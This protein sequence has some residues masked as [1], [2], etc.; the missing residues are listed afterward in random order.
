MGYNPNEPLAVVVVVS[1][2]RQFLPCLLQCL[3][4]FNIEA[5]I[6]QPSLEV[7]DETLSV[8]QAA[9]TIGF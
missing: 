1:P 8:G 3:R 2:G 9:E 7:V 5:F 4:S 6:S